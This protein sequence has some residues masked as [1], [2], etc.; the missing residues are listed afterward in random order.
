MRQDQADL[1]WRSPLEAVARYFTHAP[2]AHACFRGAEVLALAEGDLCRPVLDLGCGAG[3]FAA[4]AVAGAVDEGIDVD[5]RRLAK[6]RRTGMHCRLTQADARALPANDGSFG[7]VLSVSALEHF[8][9][10]DAVV[11]EVARVLRPGGSFVA[12]VVLADLHRHLFYPR[13]L[14]RVGL[15]RVARWYE[16][17]QDRAFD[18]RTL[19]LKETWEALLR[20]HGFRLAVS[21]RIVSPGLTRLWD[22]LLPAALPGWLLRGRGHLVWRPRWLGRWL[23]R[24]L[25][26]LAREECDEGSVLFFVAAKPVAAGCAGEGAGAN[27]APALVCS[28]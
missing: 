4:V 3:E 11:A 9:D 14:R 13:W 20:A 27:A 15:T 23:A 2:L 8:P 10:P 25:E 12:T 6:A 5:A 28:G 19:L 16:A 26:P 1:C 7:T 24:R 22:I 18:H 17:A 21:R